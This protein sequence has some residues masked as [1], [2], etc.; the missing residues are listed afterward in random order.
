MESWTYEKNSAVS[1]NFHNELNK[2][3][4]TS[5]S[6]QDD[7]KSLS[8]QFGVVPCSFI[9]YNAGDSPYIRISNCKIDL[10]SW[11]ICLLAIVASDHDVVKALELHNVELSAQHVIDLNET[12][13]KFGSI[14]ILKFEYIQIKSEEKSQMLD[15][16]KQILSSSQTIQYIS[17][18]GC[19]FGDSIIQCLLVAMQANFSIQALNLTDNCL[20]DADIADFFKALRIHPTLQHVSL[21]RNELTS[22]SLDLLENFV[23]GSEATADDEKFVKQQGK[24]IIEKNKA[25]KASNKKRKKSS[26][27]EISEIPPINDRIFSL[28]GKQY[29]INK[30]LLSIDFSKND[31]ASDTLCEF[32]QRIGISM[33]KG[34][35]SILSRESKESEKT[36]QGN[37]LLHLA[38]D[39][40]SLR[41]FF[42]NIFSE[43]ECQRIGSI[44]CDDTGIKIII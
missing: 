20:K 6:W 31:I 18:R 37:K 7:F 2:T 12:L 10:S 17:F 26:M 27:I 38:T 44:Y 11:R 14:R 23:M 41:L 3:L 21:A 4:H 1:F 40:R 33:P 15:N 19:R 39:N 16:I 22:L 9:A 34:S 29:M 43:I 8:E 32:I 5:G 35:Q 42:R 28:D 13:S 36:S 30:T 25:I 24:A